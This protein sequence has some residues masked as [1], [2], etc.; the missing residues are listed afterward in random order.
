M[1]ST[2]VQRHGSW[3]A[4]LS[5][6]APTITDLVAIQINYITWDHKGTVP[7]WLVPPNE[8]DWQEIFPVRDIS[9]RLDSSSPTV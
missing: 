4:L 8:D 7:N 5:V 6:L 2:S 9:S 1:T 3:T